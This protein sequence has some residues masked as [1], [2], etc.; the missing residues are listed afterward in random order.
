M[1]QPFEHIPVL[2][3]EAISSL[4]LQEG[5]RAV[6]VTAG[7]GGHFRAIVQQVGPSGSVLAMDRDLRAHQADAAGGVHREYR[8]NTYLVH[9]P[10][11]R[12][13]ETL[14]ELGWAGVDGLLCDLGVSSPQLDEEERGFSLKNDGPLDM[15][16]DQDQDLTAY[17][18]L[19]SSSQEDIANILFQYGEEHRSRRIARAI[20]SSWPI[21]NSTLHLA[22]LVRRA[23]GY[24]NSR[25]HPATRTFQA[26]RIA[27]NRELKELQEL[28][29]VLPE[30]LN[31]GGSAA[32]ISFHSLEDR[33]VKRAFAAGAKGKNPVWQLQTKKPITPTPE[34][35]RH[36][37]RARSSKLRAI[38]ML[39]TPASQP[40][41]IAS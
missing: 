1:T 12:I 27:V 31:P 34:E 39:E 38:T 41:E 19:E 37:P 10:F 18:L 2:F 22:D 36:N 26:L 33:M 20:K 21:P 9:R 32:I 7:G 16:M 24:R 8:E 17:D 23:S 5:S 4:A 28:L 14:E 30:V 15:R 25:V 29:D 6:D 13:K 11:S 3:D 35:I 40:L